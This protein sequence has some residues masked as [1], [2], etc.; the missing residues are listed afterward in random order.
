MDRGYDT[1]KDFGQA[2]VDKLRPI[3][4]LN[5]KIKWLTCV[6][7]LSLD[8]LVSSPHPHVPRNRLAQEPPPGSTVEFSHHFFF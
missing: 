1:P 5:C 3:I 8:D 7:K 4:L 2:V 6:L